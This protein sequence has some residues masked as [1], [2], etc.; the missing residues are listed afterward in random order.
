MTAEAQSW[1]S[2]N[3]FDFGKAITVPKDLANEAVYSAG[4]YPTLIP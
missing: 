4:K 1:N 3:D 2:D